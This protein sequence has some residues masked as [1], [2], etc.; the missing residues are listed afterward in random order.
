[1]SRLKDK[2]WQTAIFVSLALML[3][4]VSEANARGGG[5]HGGG[6]SG[7]SSAGRSFSGGSANV[8]SRSGFYSTSAAL[9]MPSPKTRVTSAYRG[10]RG[11]GGGRGGYSSYSDY[12][13][14]LQNYYQPGP[15]NGQ[16]FSGS[17]H[18]TP[19]EYGRYVQSYQW[20][21]SHP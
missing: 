1:M 13:G 16:V 3:T 11:Y 7:H 20:P 9:G 12:N 10:G 4:N 18:I 14:N 2:V 6:G 19:S 21:S 15:V 5:S 17:A 8:G